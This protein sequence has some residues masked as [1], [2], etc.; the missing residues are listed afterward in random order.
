LCTRPQDA[1]DAAVDVDG[2]FRDVVTPVLEQLLRPGE[3]DRVR[4]EPPVSGAWPPSV[5]VQLQVIAVG[6]TCH[7]WAWNPGQV[8]ETPAELRARLASELQ[9]FI[10]ESRFG[11]SELREYREPA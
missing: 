2:L 10:A 7:F 4:I 5:P 3:L 8:E 11:W 6:E 9:D 1:Q